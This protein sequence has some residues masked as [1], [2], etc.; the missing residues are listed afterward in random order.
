L[1]E[2]LNEHL[3]ELYLIPAKNA[4]TNQTIARV[5]MHLMQAKEENDDLKKRI[6]QL[7]KINNSIFTSSLLADL[8]N[9][10]LPCN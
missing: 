8:I 4:N 7:E 2:L 10:D 3:H 5:R 9:E 6:R 1:V